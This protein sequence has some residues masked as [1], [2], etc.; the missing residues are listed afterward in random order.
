VYVNDINTDKAPSYTIFNVRAGF[1]QKLSNWR[2]KEYIRI[3]NITDKDYIGSV[4][5]NDGNALF[6]EPAAGRN[7]LLGINAQYKF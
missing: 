4:R 2:F 7:Y 5:V 3:E 1:E 6:F